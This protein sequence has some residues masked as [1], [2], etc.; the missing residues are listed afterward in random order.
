MC[1]KTW[2]K[3]CNERLFP[4]ELKIVEQSQIV[5]KIPWASEFDSWG[6]E[7]VIKTNNEY[8]VLSWFIN[9]RTWTEHC[10]LVG[11]FDDIEKVVDKI[12]Y[13]RFGMSKER[14]RKM[15]GLK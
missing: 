12:Q 8:Y 2:E 5:G 9:E 10:E 13:L 6:E 1:M 3:I 7:I 14:I 15:L 11:P 4:S